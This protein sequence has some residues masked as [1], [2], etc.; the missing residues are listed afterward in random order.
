MN[1]FKEEEVLM[2]LLDKS[3]KNNP[4]DLTLDFNFHIQ[5]PIVFNIISYH[6]PVGRVSDYFGDGK[7]ERYAS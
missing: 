7:E 4:H 1:C 6:A 5:V 3:L 2:E